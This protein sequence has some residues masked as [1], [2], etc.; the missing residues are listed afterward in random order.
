MIEL[1]FLEGV[2]LVRQANQQSVIFI[3]I[4]IFQRKGLSF[5]HMSVMAVKRY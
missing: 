5:N 3:I 2:M 4:G 1:K